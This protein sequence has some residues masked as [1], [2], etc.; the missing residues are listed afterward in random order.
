MKTSL[1]NLIN[2]NPSV[3]YADSSLYTREPWKTAH[4][5]T[6]SPQSLMRIFLCGGGVQD[7]K[8]LH[9]P[10][11]GF[12]GDAVR[13]IHCMQ[14]FLCGDGVRITHRQKTPP[15]RT[16][17]SNLFGA[18]FGNGRTSNSFPTILDANALTFGR[19]NLRRPNDV[20]SRFR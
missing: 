8:H 19:L 17:P 5:R 14:I 1:R 18:N 9:S 4:P 10:A 2:Y 20:L 15:F 12:T 11:H 3:S 13:I 16:L 6:K 7:A